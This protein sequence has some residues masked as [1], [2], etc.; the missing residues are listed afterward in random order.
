[1]STALRTSTLHLRTSTRTMHLR[2]P[3]PTRSTNYF[4]R[5]KIL[6]R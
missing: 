6:S 2:T 3:A 1:M 5:I 4:H